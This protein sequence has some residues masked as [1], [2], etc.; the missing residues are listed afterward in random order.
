MNFSSFYNAKLLLCLVTFYG[1]LMLAGCSTMS[2]SVN[3]LS[4]SNEEVIELEPWENNSDIHKDLTTLPQ[5][6]GR[7]FVSVFGFQDKTGQY[8]AAPSNSFSTAVTQGASAFLVSALSDSGW[9]LPLEREGLQNI[10]TERKIIRSKSAAEIPALASA[11]IVIDGSI[12][13]YDSNILTGGAGAKYFGAGA[14]TTFRKD[15]L[16]INIKAIDVYSGQIINSVTVTKSI[17]SKEISS[18][19]FRFVKFKRLLEMEA[20]YSRNDPIQMVL[21]DAIE[22]AVIRLIATGV[23]KKNW[24]LNNPEDVAHPIMKR[25][26]AV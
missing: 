26:G 15:Q 12:I 17:L 7:M 25:Y 20:G 24:G 8:K 23:S 9:F 4:S 1:L 16:T 13:A 3:K 5:A 10:L 6:K 2:N 11:G 21:R 19:I 14:S 22:I 18:G